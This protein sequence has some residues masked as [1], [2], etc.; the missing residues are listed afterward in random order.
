MIQYVTEGFD[1]LLKAFNDEVYLK[2]LTRL[3]KLFDEGEALLERVHWEES[4]GEITSDVDKKVLNEMFRG[5]H[6]TLFSCIFRKAKIEA[7][8][9]SEAWFDSTN[10]QLITAMEQR[11]EIQP[12]IGLHRRLDT[13]GKSRN[14]RQIG[15]PTSPP[16]LSSS[17]H[18]PTISRA[19]T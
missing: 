16:Y 11:C 14:T 7:V 13:L 12:V 1:M 18:I 3:D 15:L 9:R 2:T 17:F 6:I 8:N 19:S 10:S 4:E 5:N